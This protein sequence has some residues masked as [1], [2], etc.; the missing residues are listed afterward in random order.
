[1]TD[2]LAPSNTEKSSYHLTVS[3]TQVQVVHIVLFPLRLSE[4]RFRYIDY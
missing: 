1:M 2:S 3:E 4:V